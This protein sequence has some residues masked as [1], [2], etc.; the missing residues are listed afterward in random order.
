MPAR[1]AAR[2]EQAAKKS[3]TSTPPDILPATPSSALNTT[4]APEPVDEPQKPPPPPLPTSVHPGKPLP[5]VEGAA[6]SV[7]PPQK[8]YQSIQERYRVAVR[9]SSPHH[10]CLN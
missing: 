6:Q 8:D 5:T 1:A 3:R 9:P 2:V 7:T 10:A 4:P